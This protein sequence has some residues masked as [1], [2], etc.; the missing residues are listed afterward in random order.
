MASPSNTNTSGNNNN[1]NINNNNSAKNP[2]PETT[3]NYAGSPSSNN[4]GLA[5]NDAI[6]QPE[7]N[8]SNS[9]EEIFRIPSYSKWFSWDKIHSTEKRFLPEFFD[10]KSAAKIPRVYKYYRD[11][12]IDKYRAN[13]LRKITYTEVRKNL[14]GDVNSVRRVFEFLEN[15]GLINFHVVSSKQQQQQHLK[16]EDNSKLIVSNNNGGENASGEGKGVLPAKGLVPPGDRR[17]SLTAA[18]STV[19]DRKG[20][21]AVDGKDVYLKDKK[22]EWPRAVL[23]NLCRAEC[24]KLRF[25]CLKEIKPKIEDEGL[26]E[27][28]GSNS[29]INDISAEGTKTSKQEPEEGMSQKATEEDPKDE[30]NGGE[31]EPNGD[32]DKILKKPDKLLRCP[33]CDSLGT[34]FCYYNNYNVNQPRYFCRNCQRYWTA[35]GTMRNVPIGAG[36]RKNKHSGSFDWSGMKLDDAAY[37]Q[38]DFVLCPKCYANGNYGPGLSAGDF[39]RVEIKEEANQYKSVQWTDQETLLLLEGIMHY[40][41]DWKHVA[42]HVGTKSE[43]DCVTRFIQLPFGEEYMGNYGKESSDRRSS[44]ASGESITIKHF[45]SPKDS[46]MQEHK[47]DTIYDDMQ[48]TDDDVSC[49]P[50][51]RR[52][53]TPF[54]DASNPIMAQVAFL[55]T[56]AGSHVAE[57]AASAA[58]ATLCE[59]DH[60]V[61]QITNSQLSKSLNQKNGIAA[62]MQG[63]LERDIQVEDGKKELHEEDGEALCV[64][65]DL[66]PTMEGKSV[67]ATALKSAA[68][69]AKLLV[70]QEEQ[71][72][73]HIVS[74]IIENQMKQLEEKIKHFDEREIITEKSCS[75]MEQINDHLFTDRL[76]FL[77][78]TSRSR[79]SVSQGK[80][81]DGT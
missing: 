20:S 67:T 6:P 64:G 31:V 18:A 7:F 39:K 13:P 69:R 3:S 63:G 62:S 11:F 33:R 78:K 60:F 36:R 49:P 81:L 79:F 51:K 9:P 57:A 66:T 55:S 76:R 16:T 53:L 80:K 8:H 32:K 68:E 35:G 41:D 27:E 25:D 10:G 50:L 56:M 17:P 48:S 26:H 43:A 28:P 73:E 30:K 74:T 59:D 75:Q 19:T 42:Q 21:T 4:A 1:N 37:C 70:D 45:S 71:D 24:A 54:A 44:N 29:G 12:I 34:K 23:C 15:W 22:L 61:S 47:D 14:V 65:K 77:Q 52:H 5:P 46:S 58:V 72:I 2:T 40:N 38:A